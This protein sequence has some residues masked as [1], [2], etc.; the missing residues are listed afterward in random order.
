M[1]SLPFR[2]RPPIG[3]VFATST[4]QIWRVV[5]NE[6]GDYT[7][8]EIIIVIQTWTEDDEAAR[9]VYPVASFWANVEAGIWSIKAPDG[10]WKDI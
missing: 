8:D 3:T 10:M 9:T 6:S 1:S 4:G 5:P 7:D 2:E